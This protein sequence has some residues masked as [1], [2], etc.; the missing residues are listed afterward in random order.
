MNEWMNYVYKSFYRSKPSSSSQLLQCQHISEA[1]SWKAQHD[2]TVTLEQTPQA[3]FTSPVIWTT[4][5]V[6]RSGQ[7]SSTHVWLHKSAQCPSAGTSPWPRSLLSPPP[8]GPREPLT[9]TWG[10]VVGQASAIDPIQQWIDGKLWLFNEAVSVFWSDWVL[11]A[12]KLSK[13][14]T[15]R[16][17]LLKKN[18][19][20]IRSG[21]FT[22]MSKDEQTK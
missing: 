20:L 7:H 21:R 5:F 22:S 12:I 18:N 16:K 9:R 11:V 3:T 10:V 15:P 14:T 1:S 17:K 19:I 8:V 4:G 13:R 2:I 6:R